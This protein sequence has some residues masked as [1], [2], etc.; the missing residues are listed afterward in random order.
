MVR[1]RAS[2]PIL[3]VAKEMKKHGCVYLAFPGG[4][5]ALAA[6]DIKSVEKMYWQD[7]GLAEALWVFQVES[8]GPMVVAIDTRGGNLYVRP[9]PK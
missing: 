4:T 6:R 5:G 1:V 8:F 2:T 9:K 7:L 3:D